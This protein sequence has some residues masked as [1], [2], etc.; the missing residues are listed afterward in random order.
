MCIRDRADVVGADAG[1]HGG[2]AR[3]G[4][5]AFQQGAQHRLGVTPAAMGRV[6]GVGDLDD[7]VPVRRPVEASVTDDDPFRVADRGAGD[8][9]GGRRVALNVGEA[10]LPQPALLDQERAQRS[11]GGPARGVQIA[12]D[13]GRQ[14]GRGK[15]HESDRRHP[16]MITRRS[17]VRHQSV[18]HN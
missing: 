16:A 12:V 13:E 18:V 2:H 5:G 7:T 4:V 1:A 17:G 9:V 6:D 3:V 8:P 10:D 14:G 15:L 11:S